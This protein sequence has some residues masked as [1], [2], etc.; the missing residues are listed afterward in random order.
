M[1]QLPKK[2]FYNVISDFYLTKVFINKLKMFSKFRTPN[3]LKEKHFQ[4]IDD[5]SYY[6]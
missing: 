3:K 5:K 1:Q 2:T 6:Y 4:M